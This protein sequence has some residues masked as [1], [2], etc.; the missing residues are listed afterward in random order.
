MYCFYLEDRETTR[1]LPLHD[2]VL[3]AGRAPDNEIVLDDPSVPELA[4][5]LTLR[6]DGAA[7]AVLQPGW[8]PR[9]NGLPCDHAVLR[10]GDRLEAGSLVLTLAAQEGGEGGGGGP[11]AGGPG[12]RVD[13]RASLTRLCTLVAGE[14]DLKGLLEKF[15]GLLLEAFRG[16]EAFLF[17]LDAAGKPAVSV[18]SRPG[19][20]EKLFSD[21]VV[22]RVLESGRGLFVRNAMA[23]PAFSQSRSIS[24]LKLHS[25]L[26][27][28]IAAA[29]RVTGLIYLGSSAPAVSYEERDLRELEVYALIAG[30]LINHVDYIA[31]QREMLA[32]LRTE[33]EAG[34]VAFSAPMQ[35][36]LA[37][38]RAVA[39]SDIS[40]LLQGE[41]GT[42]KD[43]IAGLLHRR[44][45]RKDKPFLVVNCSTLRGELLAS[46]LFG[47]RKGSFTGASADQKG[48]FAAADGG[49][50]F[51]DEIGDM[52]LPL[53]AMLLRTLETGKVRPVGQ[54]EEITVDVR[55]LCATHRDLE[56]MVSAGAFRQDLFYR[57]NQHAIR[58][59]PLRERGED[60]LLLAQ[61]FLDKARALYPGKDVRGFAPES[62][63]AMALHP[64]PGNVRELA[65]AVHKA[66]LFAE[67]PV[68]R[69][70]LPEAAS[71]WADLE[72]ATRRFQGD[73][74]RRCLDFCGGDKEKAAALLG[75]GRSTLFRHLSQ[76][77]KG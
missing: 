72:D 49:T 4:F 64:W 18:A 70:A 13:F 21:T 77:G 44:G 61:A 3:T 16:D 67:S 26:C 42:G 2:T 22:A 36:V 63:A 17:S 55:I 14:R 7:L 9:V 20:K 1:L 31:R 66:V 47:H 75:M 8:S 68:A 25:V 51:L 30:C 56:S 24:D 34:L 54:A 23:D 43:L 19:G 76:A 48:L 62:L 65:N 59:P 15:M 28:P 29:G 39:G 46:E 10:P 6:E 45:R 38:V 53:Q 71:G 74:I 58:L 5:R 27:C 11:P 41:T 50:L 40:V 60:I 33:G 35:R 12:A 52:D 73:Y 32:A 37:E 69:I 57:I